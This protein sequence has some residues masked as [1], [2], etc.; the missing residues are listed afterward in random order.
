MDAQDIIKYCLDSLPDTVLVNSW[1]ESGIFYNPNN[2]L[3]RGIYV[4]T[5]KEK[6]GDN[7]KSSDLDRDSIF[8]VNIGVRKNTFVNMFGSIPKRPA[9]GGVVDMP[10]DFARTNKILPHPIYAWMSWIC[11]LNPSQQTFEKLKP[12]IVEAY[13][14]AKEK[15]AKRR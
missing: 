13:N 6:D 4:L 14:Y 7:D 12:L 2:A 11:A 1:G 10:F 9:K 5:V 3:K 8:R 15:Y